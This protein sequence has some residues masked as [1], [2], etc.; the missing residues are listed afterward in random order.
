MLLAAS[1]RGESPATR[2]PNAEAVL[3]RQWKGQW[4]ACAGAPERDARVFRFRKV[5]LP[6]GA[7]RFVVHVSGD[8]LFVLFA[9][10]Q[11]VGIGPSRGDIAHWRFQTFDLAPFLKVGRNLVVATDWNFGTQDPDA[12]VS[13]RTGF[14]VQGRRGERSARQYRRVV[15]VRARAGPSAVAGGR[16]GRA[17]RGRLRSRRW[18]LF[19]GSA[20]MAP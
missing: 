10:G 5:R 9:D 8:Q 3:S 12:Q 13:D 16:Q 2:P 17:R 19:Q 4:I 6:G 7:E 11:R 18:S 14:V 1:V 15:A 20:A